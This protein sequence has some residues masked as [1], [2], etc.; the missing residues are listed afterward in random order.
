MSNNQP[1]R[2]SYIRAVHE[3]VPSEE[4]EKFM[5]RVVKIGLDE[6]GYKDSTLVRKRMSREVQLSPGVGAS[7]EGLGIDAV[8][9]YPVNSLRATVFERRAPRN[10][11][12]NQALRRLFDRLVDLELPTPMLRP[13]ERLRARPQ[14]VIDSTNESH[15]SAIR[16]LALV[17]D[18]GVAENLFLA[19]HTVLQE[20]ADRGRQKKLNRAIYGSDTMPSVV[21]I[22][23]VPASSD[24]E[25]VIAFIDRVNDDELGSSTL[26][27]EFEPLEWR[28]AIR[29]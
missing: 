24:V 19:E 14:Y 16:E 13:G 4:L 20:E 6:L 18:E 8:H 2:L 9:P 11:R 3:V 22:L 28:T 12:D 17:L 23:T 15:G 26:S 27:L 10:Q 7:Y 1:D 5:R 21:P 29:R 25:Q